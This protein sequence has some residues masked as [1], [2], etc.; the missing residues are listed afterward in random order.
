M[1]VNIETLSEKIHKNPLPLA[2]FGE[3]KDTGDFIEENLLFTLHP[4]MQFE[5]STVH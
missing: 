4:Y 5:L 1:L 2:H 3:S